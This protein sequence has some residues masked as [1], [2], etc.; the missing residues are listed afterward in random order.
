MYFIIFT[1]Y[2][3]NASPKIAI[4]KENRDLKSQCHCKTQ[5]KHLD[6]KIREHCLLPLFIITLFLFIFLHNFALHC[7]FQHHWIF[8]LFNFYKT[9]KGMNMYPTLKRK[10]YKIIFCFEKI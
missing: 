10:K 1:V 3:S 7:I 8:Y 6:G 2:N 4:A 9:Y 5:I